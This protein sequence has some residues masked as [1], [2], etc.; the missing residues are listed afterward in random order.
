MPGGG[1]G[2][3][4]ERK[5]FS[6]DFG[7]VWTE[8]ETPGKVGGHGLTACQN[9][10][11][12]RYGAWG[13]RPG[14]SKAFTGS[15]AGTR[16]SDPVSGF[17]WYAAFPNPL[18]Q[19]L[20]VAQG[21]LYVA[22]ANGPL[23]WTAA[24]TRTGPL[25]A[26]FAPVRDPAWNAGNGQDVLIICGVRGGFSFD[27]GTIA[28]SGTPVPGQTIYATMQNGSA[29]PI[30]SAT[31]T[32]IATDNLVTIANNLAQLINES[33]AV[34]TGG[35]VPPFLSQA[36]TG[37]SA[38]A[39]TVVLGAL[40]SGGSSGIT[41]S[42]TLGGPSGF[43]ATPTSSTPFSGGGSLTSAPVKWDG[44]TL[45]GLSYQISQAFTG[46]V[47][48]HNH[49]WYWGDP[50]N[51]DTLYAS[52]IDQPEGFTF[53]NENGGYEIGPGD[54][55]PAIQMCVAIGDTLYVFK[56]N[57]I[58]AVTGYDFQSGEY[59]FAVT[60]VVK[61]A[62]IPSPACVGVLNNAV[63]FWTG[64]EFCR[65]AV[66]SFDLE[67]IGRPI[68]LTSGKVSAGNNA[69]VQAIA[70]NALVGLSLPDVYSGPTVSPQA[71]L[72][73][74]ALFAVDTGDGVADTVLMYDDDAS[75]VLGDYAWSL[76]SGTGWQVGSW[77]GIG[78]GS[79]TS[80]YDLPEILW[81]PPQS[82]LGNN[83][84]VV[85]QLGGNATSDNRSPIAFMAQTGWVELRNTRALETVARRV[86]DGRGASRCNDQR[87]NHPVRS[88]D[89]RLPGTAAGR[90]P[91]VPNVVS[92][93]GGRSRRR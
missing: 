36:T 24:F 73:N 92:D 9:L 90:V 27:S 34:E 50:N 26:S 6:V 79:F 12:R 2:S 49:V 18:T 23:T 61:G 35:S 11:Y 81:I 41:Y 72:G 58:Y 20:V 30:V 74:I 62:G 5:F 42:V 29:T 19:L 32:V 13:K 39:P 33:T 3:A 37:G 51:P 44:T 59:A 21:A 91:S 75:Q 86:P 78:G 84:P 48:W 71:V 83:P 55:D 17:R 14:Y 16:H 68:P 25:P 60:S 85:Y 28:F 8:A 64:S 54:G 69:L 7:G 65:L 80:G 40:V 70:G 88:V 53:M 22:S 77:I 52:D 47:T 89:E 63:V 66:G 46:C 43:T 67:H 45:S 10:V 56:Q 38:T 1:A 31:Y 15:Q 87:A 57:S 82:V 4:P 76:W 93:H